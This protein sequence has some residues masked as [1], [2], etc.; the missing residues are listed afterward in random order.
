MSLKSRF[1]RVALACFLILSMFVLSFADTIHL[2]NGIIIKGRIVSFGDG[3]FTVLIG[4]GARQRQ[5]NFFADEIE[6]IEFDSGAMQANSNAKTS[7]PTYTDTSGKKD[8]K[9]TV[10]TVGQNDTRPTPT[11][12]PVPSKTVI[13]TDNTTATVTPTPVSTPAPTPIPT[14]V[15][16]DTTSKPITLNVKVL[17]DN[18]ANGWT[19]SGWV[20]RKGQ[21]IRITGKG[22]ISLGNGRYSSPAGVSSL[23]DKD[24]LIQKEATGG[25]IA[26]IG[27]DNNE[28]IFVGASREFVAPRDGALFLGVNEGNLDD[29][30][31]SFEVTIEI[32]PN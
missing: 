12:T 6:S 29:N 25:L 16:T 3:Q 8:N 32:T 13:I 31:G 15:R 23:P 28:F 18:T 20:V 7:L 22:Q 9:N 17:A 19:N 4:E 27:D 24:K 14:P 1:N 10:I 26:V 2:K 11:P 21:K 5:M 30:S